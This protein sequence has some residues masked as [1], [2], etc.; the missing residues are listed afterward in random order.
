MYNP[1]SSVMIFPKINTRL[2]GTLS[3]ILCLP[4]M[5]ACVSTPEKKSES[6]QELLKEGIKESKEQ[7]NIRAKAVFQQI[8]EDYPDSKQRIHALLFLARAYYSDEEFEE[9]KFHFQK[10][11]DL[12]PAHAQVDRAYYFR[13]MSDFKL[14]DLALRDQTATREAI[15]GFQQL[16]DRFPKSQYLE[17]AKKKKRECELKLAKN[18]FEIGKFYYRT[19]SYQSAIIRFKNLVAEHP[20]YK[21]LDEAM[22]LIAESYYYEQ[23]FGEASLSYKELLQKYPKGRFSIQARSRLR[24]LRR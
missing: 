8:L 18:V 16:I 24:T 6:A 17:E 4:I 15:E 22:F 3:I 7:S 13:A 9:A 2:V 5:C 19:G 21:D 10:F 12:Y 1:F 14:V 23:S 20:K 11:I